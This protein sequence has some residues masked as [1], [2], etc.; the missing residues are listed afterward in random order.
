MKLWGSLLLAGLSVLVS[1]CET[2][3]RGT[4]QEVSIETVPA[5]ASILLSDGQRCTSPCRL[6]APRY[7]ILTAH[8]SRLDCRSTISHLVPAVSDDATVFGSVFDYQLGGA[9]DLDPKALRV[10][11]VCGTEARQPPLGLTPEDDALLQEFGR[12]APT[13]PG[14]VP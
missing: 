14:I 11:L 7:Q 13:A 9:Y 12:P 2:I 6:I 1:A 3:V 4:H 8:I 5:G 10:N